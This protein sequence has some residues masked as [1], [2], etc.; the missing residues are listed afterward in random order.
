M[1]VESN[2]LAKEEK[3]ATKNE[4]NLTAWIKSGKIVP[5][6]VAPSSSK[7]GQTIKKGVPIASNIIKTNPSKMINEQ[8]KSSAYGR[9]VPYYEQRRFVK[10][11]IVLR[12]F[13]S[14]RYEPQSSISVTKNEHQLSSFLVLCSLR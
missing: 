14:T 11:E 1:F 12:I 7:D 3:I 2:K 6:L 9:G 8:K 10:Y 5:S 13:F 4:K